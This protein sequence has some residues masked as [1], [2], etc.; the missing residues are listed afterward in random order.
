[1]KETCG[2]LKKKT[3]WKGKKK[4]MD[5]LWEYSFIDRALQVREP[6]EE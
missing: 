5:G 2:S 3:E 6:Q 4:E 1:M